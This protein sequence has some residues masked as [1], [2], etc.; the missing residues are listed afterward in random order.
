MKKAKMTLSVLAIIVMIST[1]FSQ[2]KYAILITGDNNAINVPSN[3]QWNNGQGMGDYGYDEFWNDTYLFWELL[4][5]EKEY[6][7]ENIYVLYDEGVDLDF[8]GQDDRYNA[9][10]TYG[11]NIT[12]QSSTQSNVQSIFST[13][14]GTITKIDFLFVW[15]MS[16]GGTDAQGSY[17]YS[18]DA[19]K[20]YDTQL[21]TWLGN[22]DAYKK[23]VFL[24]TPG[25]GG[26]TEEL[27]G[28]RTVVIS[29]SE[30]NESAS[31]SDNLDPNGTPLLDHPENEEIPPSSG[32]TYNHGEA[33]YHLYSSL[34]G[35]TPDFQTS[36]AGVELTEADLNDDD[37]I[38]IGEAR[39]WEVAK[40]SIGNE[41]PGFSDYSV[42][43]NY[44][45]LELPTI[46]HGTIIQ[47]MLVRGDIGITKL[48][49]H[50]ASGASFTFDGI[51]NIIELLEDNILY[52]DIGTTTIVND[53]CELN[54]NG[55]LP[56]VKGFLDFGEYVTVNS[57]NGLILA[58]E[59]DA[60]INYM[61]FQKG[62]LA[63]YNNVLTIENSLFSPYTKIKYHPKDLTVNKSLFIESIIDLK[64]PTHDFS[65][66][67]IDA[68]IFEDA[69]PWPYL[70]SIGLQNYE[71]YSITNCNLNDVEWD[72][73][74]LSYCGISPILEVITLIENDSIC[75]NESGT[76]IT[77]SNTNSDIK[78]NKIVRNKK[79]ILS[80]NKSKVLVE[81]NKQALNFH[82][83]QEI[84]GNQFH[85][86]YAPS[87]YS[88]PYYVKWNYILASTNSVYYAI[89]ASPFC[90]SEYDITYN[91]WGPGFDP[92]QAEKYFHPVSC[93]FWEPVWALGELGEITYENDEQLY[94][95]ANEKVGQQDY[96]GAE[97][98]FI[99][100]INN[101]PG[102]RFSE[103]ALKDLFALEQET[104]NN[105]QDLQSYYLTDNTIQN[106]ENLKKLAA[107]LATNCDIILED[108][109]T[110]LNNYYD[111]I[112]DSISYNDSLVALINIEYVNFLIENNSYNK[113]SDEFL[114]NDIFNPNNE[115]NEKIKKYE[116]LF[117][118]PAK[119]SLIKNLEL[120]KP[121]KLL[122]NFPNPATNTTTIYYKLSEP[123]TVCLKLFNYSGQV[124]NTFYEGYKPIGTHHVVVDVSFLQSGIYFNNIEVNGQIVDTKKI[125][126]Q[127]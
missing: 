79:G 13:L 117:F 36:Y 105:Y 39:D 108:Y 11:F 88:V 40:E 61:S 109:Q 4:N 65:E 62:T 113:S 45:E 99:N 119:S 10:E 116:D 28:E 29:S 86:I 70:A 46:L 35:E 58:Q 33:N 50:V 103:E 81:G 16:H 64:D 49:P 6:S 5:E 53:N 63:L 18:Y 74:R 34:A 44:T 126:V 67:K 55:D 89:A 66:V 93:F 84:H 101:Y 104:G 94:I 91:Y 24:S 27:E 26:F 19:Q 7:N 87:E 75:F 48:K 1:T 69:N 47:D 76:A 110:A 9:L 68:C 77:L 56:Y 127:N 21:A 60:Y 102:S 97:T 14:A 59:N 100:L 98:E 118:N 92:G 52:F 120:L 80:Y 54:I 115:Y 8:P 90:T 30:I 85:Q 83:T 17:F 15:V 111:L 95:L 57:D 25:S 106:N 3:D 122:Q 71:S 82:E 78:N 41:G 37:Y 23:T 72:A 121:G 96:Y 107:S 20:I 114:I 12:D 38:S 112:N 124:V 22:I 73:I 43:S 31:R 123:A 2:E 32:N 51:I 42:I 125:L